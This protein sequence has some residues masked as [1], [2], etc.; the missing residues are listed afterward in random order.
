MTTKTGASDTIQFQL[1]KTKHAETRQ[2]QRGISD[3]QVYDVLLWGRVFAQGGGRIAHFLGRS[4]CKFAARKG[5]DLWSMQGTTV[6]TSGGE[7]IVTVI[8]CESPRKIKKM[9]F[10]APRRKEVV[11]W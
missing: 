10:K 4:E 2:Q 8:R 1:K 11:L 3:A 6:V 7:I 9:Q 5:V